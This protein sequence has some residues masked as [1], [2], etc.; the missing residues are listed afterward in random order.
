MILPGRLCE[1][2]RAW[3]T[4][5]VFPKA[6]PSSICQV[7]Y[8][9]SRIRMLGHPLHFDSKQRLRSGIDTLCAT[10]IGRTP[11]ETSQKIM[12]GPVKD[13][14]F[15]RSIISDIKIIIDQAV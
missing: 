3:M 13:L 10:L 8:E 14:P 9:G 2:I 4:P 12:R 1:L 5:I 7:N 11:A 6:P 15:L